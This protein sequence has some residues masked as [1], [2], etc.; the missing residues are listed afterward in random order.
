M[1]ITINGQLKTRRTRAQ[2]H[3]ALW[4]LLICL[5]PLLILACD[6]FAPTDPNYLDKLHEE[7][8]WANA[9]RLT[10]RLEY[11]GSWGN[12]NPNRGQISPNPLD[13]RQGYEFAVEFTP[14]SGYGFVEW[15]AFN[16]NQYEAGILSGT[17]DSAKSHTAFLAGDTL[18]A[19]GVE[20]KRGETATGAIT[21]AVTINSNIP[22]TL[23]PFCDNMPR[24]VRSNPPLTTALTPFPYNQKVS[25][26]FNMPIDIDTVRLNASTG[27]LTENIRINAVHSAGTKNGQPA[28]NEG[29]ISDYFRVSEYSAVEYRLDLIAT[30]ALAEW[31]AGD[32]VMSLS[33]S[34]GTGVKNTAGFGMAA[35]QTISYMT[36]ATETQKVYEANSIEASRTA[37]PSHPVGAAWIQT[38]F[39]DA[40][41]QWNNPDIDRRFNKTTITTVY[42]RFTVGNPEGVTNLPNRITVREALTNH[43]DGSR[44]SGSA[45]WTYE[46]ITPQADGYYYISHNLRTIAPGIIQLVIL[47]W[48]EDTAN[49]ENN[50][51]E[52]NLDSAISAMRFVTVVQDTDAPG[53]RNPA[54]LIN[55]T[56][57]GSPETVFTLS[58]GAE[59]G[60]ILGNI[61]DLADNYVEGGIRYGSAYSRPWT[62]DEREK[63]Q[64]RWCIGKKG[65]EPETWYVDSGWRACGETSSQSVLGLTNGQE[66]SV[67]VYYCDTMGNVSAVSNA[68]TVRVIAGAPVSVSGIWAE[69]TGTT[70]T[71]NWTTVQNPESN[72]K[73]A[74]VLVNGVERENNT[75]TTAGGKSFS[76]SVP[77][78]N[79][80][81]IRTAGQ[82]AS[83]FEKYDISVVGYND[84]GNAPAQTLTVWNVPEMK[85]SNEPL[86]VSNEQ[87][88]IQISSADNVYDPISNTVGLANISS[89]S[90]YLSR[91]YVLVN[92][93]AVSGHTPIGT[94]EN[95]FRGKFYG[96]GHTVTITGT[97]TAADSGLF[98][99]VGDNALARD[100]TVQY[101]T[102]TVSPTGAARFG[103]IAGR[104]T[105]KA[106]LENVLTRGSAEFNVGGDTTA[107]VGGIVGLLGRIEQTEISAEGSAST[108]SIY[109]AYGG[110]NLQVEKSSQTANANGS[111]YA[112]GIA[113][114]IG[115]TGAFTAVNSAVT[116]TWAGDAVEL[117]DARAV[118]NISVGSEGKVYVMYF[119][120]SDTTIP[121]G[122]QVGGIAG[123]VFG[124][125][126][127]QQAK[128]RNSEYRQG[129]I[130]VNAGY[131][132]NVI[133]GAIGGIYQYAK[134]TDCSTIAQS[135]DINKTTSG[136]IYAGGFIG[137]FWRNGTIENCY[138]ENTISAAVAADMPVT[139][140]GFGGRIAAKV[141][142]CYALGNVSGSGNYISY[143]G[144]FAGQ[145]IATGT[146]S[147]CY[148]AGNVTA[149]N[150][151]TGNSTYA[152]GFAGRSFSLSDCYALGDVLAQKPSGG[153]VYAG[154]LVGYFNGGITC[155]F[156]AGSVV[157]KRDSGTVYAGGLAGIGNSLSITNS[158]ALGASV[159]ATSSGTINIGRVYGAG[160]STNTNNYAYSGMKIFNNSTTPSSITTGAHNN[161]N[162]ADATL[163]KFQDHWFWRDTMRFNPDVW[164]FTTVTDRGYPI[165]RGP[166]DSFVPGGVLGGQEQGV[167]VG[168]PSTYT[169]TF[170]STGGS[171]VTVD[172]WQRIE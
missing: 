37:P 83:G 106:R 135:I 164:L 92:D 41:T 48:Y 3:A 65:T 95:T 130:T 157:V 108:A 31:P 103:G 163:A 139:V 16:S 129:T 96:N 38:L 10:V 91:Q 109:N 154:G 160:T 36:N 122:L 140:G 44:A 14:L 79:S 15:L 69:S 43:L 112:G 119:N 89:I 22:V 29:D 77:Q 45:E 126:D 75:I 87:P 133:G 117:A 80:G 13:I 169:Y 1:K 115:A 35:A 51:T 20:I 156:A 88:A 86:A 158:A 94:S 64:W 81:S 5:F 25:L 26:W 74:R 46:N 167:R 19:N 59:I 110:L 168:V 40:A 121:A 93:I 57:V 53:L 114:S 170:P 71:V 32:L 17:L 151:A 56:A 9:A 34:V 111:I 28:G 6:L 113:G 24:V 61:F 42:V 102:V 47:P 152:G 63:L 161:Q 138:S 8:S 78:I 27:E 4:P 120:F 2:H 146:A 23:V 116:I 12:S 76:F 159:T 145:F 7:I 171:T 39:R 99:V 72:M 101:N 21:A 100:L 60:L 84:A 166:N 143:F 98:G 132:H 105:G 18:S 82:E 49:E 142:Y 97:M 118:G 50:I 33:I 153:T 134:V 55:G 162:G 54:A 62:M 123:M 144:G 73:G 150:G 148:A 11:D 137:E 124:V 104:A 147:Y 58:G 30:A 107:H 85:I 66:Y 136:I 127:S 128:L 141:S 172:T 70:V 125:E 68:A 165:L 149:I 90:D 67:E 155:S 52:Q 131:G